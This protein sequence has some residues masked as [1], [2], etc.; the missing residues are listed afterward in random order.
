MEVE[1]VVNDALIEAGDLWPVIEPMGFGIDIYKGEEECRRSQQRLEPQRQ[2]FAARWYVQEVNNGGHKQFYWNS[3]G[4]VW[5]DASDGFAKMAALNEVA[6][7]IILDS[8]KLLGGSHLSI[9]AVRQTQLEQLRPS[10]GELD[11]RFYRL[12]KSVDINAAMLA[13]VKANSS[14]FHFSGKVTRREKSS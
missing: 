14:S 7:D 10:F 3:T 9:A 4:I 8:A 13:Y 2:L 12:E 6:S 1:I 11:K 5:Q